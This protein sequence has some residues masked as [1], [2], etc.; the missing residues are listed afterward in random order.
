MTSI[1]FL[2]TKYRRIE[3]I[4]ARQFPVFQETG[5]SAG[6]LLVLP[7]DYCSEELNIFF[8]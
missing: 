1:F 3:D 5:L 2:T 8:A 7:G 6:D 4:T